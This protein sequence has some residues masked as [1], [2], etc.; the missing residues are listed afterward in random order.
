MIAGPEFEKIS[1][2]Y[3][4]LVLFI[5]FFS[6]SSFLLKK[7]TGQI[8]SSN[9]FLALSGFFIAMFVVSFLA[10][11]YFYFNN[12]SLFYNRSVFAI[13]DEQ[14]AATED[15]DLV[16]VNTKGDVIDIGGSLLQERNWE[17]SANADYSIDMKRQEIILSSTDGKPAYVEMKVV[18]TFYQP[19]R[20][21]QVQLSLFVNNSSDSISYIST[22]ESKNGKNYQ[23]DSLCDPDFKDC[24]NYFLSSFFYQHNGKEFDGAPTEYRARLYATGKE[25]RFVKPKL[26]AVRMYAPLYMYSLRKNDS[27]DSNALHPKSIPDFFNNRSEVMNA[28][29]FKKNK[30]AV[31]NRSKIKN[32]VLSKKTG[33]AINGVSY[34]WNPGKGGSYLK[35]SINKN[36]Q[37]SDTFLSGIGTILIGYKNSFPENPINISL[38]LHASGVK[39]HIPVENEN[40][41]LITSTIPSESLDISSSPLIKKDNSYL[42]SRFLG[43]KFD[44]DWRYSQNKDYTFL[45]RRFHRNISNLRVLTLVFNSEVDAE[46]LKNIGYVLRL[47]NGKF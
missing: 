23:H 25:V 12:G 21:Y 40:L 16:D 22:F 45:Q 36:L 41:D 20:Q 3:I 2:L 31:Y 5:A 8:R 19:R 4:Y 29:N 14:Y 26:T 30:W 6:I 32:P 18:S 28:T 44:S 7:Y 38:L 43:L 46:R 1:Y 10:E 42:A 11:T 15:L 33:W 13:E 47:S 27:H 17:A 9:F 34:D 35:I 24:E 37:L 39:L